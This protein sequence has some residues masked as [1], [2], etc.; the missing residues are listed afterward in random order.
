VTTPDPRHTKGVNLIDLVKTFR[1]LH[2]A[3]TIPD[4]PPED[5]RFLTE[6]ILVSSWYPLADFLRVAHR[7]HAAMGG[8]DDVAQ[9]MG[10]VGA[11]ATLE[12]VHRIFLREGD[13]EATVR[14]LERV[15]TNYFDF[16]EVHVE[17]AGDRLQVHVDGYADMPRLH[18]QILVGWIRKAMELAGGNP[19]TTELVQGP[20]SGSPRV[21]IR[22]EL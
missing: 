20:W 18:G 7:V 9:M 5:A 1:A 15:W 17:R 21:T 8:T 19:H 6:R 2:R 22:V 16:G 14:S 13:P 4:P 12:G 11:Q 3:G 10:G